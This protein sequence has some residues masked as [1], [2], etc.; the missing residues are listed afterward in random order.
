M[1]R[2]H[3]SAAREECGAG[4]A[5]IFLTS[6]YWVLAFDSPFF[7]KIILS[8][9]ND[10]SVDAKALWGTF[11]LVFTSAAGFF[12]I[13][14]AL[15]KV[16]SLLPERVFKALL[17]ILSFAGAA[18]LTASLLYGATM[19]PEMIRNFLST[20]MAEVMDYLSLLTAAAFL[21]AFAPGALLAL[22]FRKGGAEAFCACPSRRP[23]PPL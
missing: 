16:L 14:A 21:L 15:L 7:A 20:D 6:A 13:A 8:A 2:R 11:L 18:S 10:P 19:T 3:L 5:V 1:R 4:L 23:K 9:A 22:S 17:L 12:L